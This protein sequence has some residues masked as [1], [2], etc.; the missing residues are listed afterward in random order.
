MNID[1]NLDVSK[2][3]Y[4]FIKL[5]IN[6]IRYDDSNPTFTYIARNCILTIASKHKIYDVYKQFHIED[7]KAL[8]LC[9]TE[10]IPEE[11]LI[12][13]LVDKKIDMQD[14]VVA[15]KG[16]CA[17]PS[18]EFNYSYYDDNKFNYPHLA[19]NNISKHNGIELLDV[20]KYEHLS[21]S[22]KLH[23]VE[24]NKNTYY[25]MYT[26]ISEDAIKYFDLKL[27]C[28]SEIKK[29][30]TLILSE[31]ELLRSCSDKDLILPANNISSDSLI[32]DYDVII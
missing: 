11:Y 2:L 17:Y 19:I 18:M 16:Y 12:T 24:F 4:K 21:D 6:M 29:L 22:E 23:V 26:S 14:E 30:K 13:M 10:R 25:L 3:Y 9:P 27:V 28:S 31:M 32:S 8:N 5:P 7:V 1:L 20:I 15:A